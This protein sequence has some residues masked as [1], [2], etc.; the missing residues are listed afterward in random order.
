MV[1]D[2]EEEMVLEKKSTSVAKSK[3][4]ASKSEA[5]DE[6]IPKKSVGK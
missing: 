3:K 1:E 2:T 4:V 6:E 5:I